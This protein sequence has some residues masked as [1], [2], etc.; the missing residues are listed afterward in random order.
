MT[1]AGRRAARIIPL[2]P[3]RRR[4]HEWRRLQYLGPTKPARCVCGA[5]RSAW[6]IRGMRSEDGY[7]VTTYRCRCGRRIVKVDA[8]E[9]GVT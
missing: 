2:T 3:A 4:E 8:A 6:R 7:R 5:T 9:G 1:P